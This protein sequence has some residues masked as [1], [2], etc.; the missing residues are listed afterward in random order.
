MTTDNPRKIPLLLLDQG[1][2][3]NT[4]NFANP[5]YIGD[6]L[7]AIEIFNGLMI[8]ELVIIDL[9]AAKGRNQINFELL[10]KI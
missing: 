9:G 1:K 3:V 2:V 10:E 6:P 8:D 7:N 5:R 4:K